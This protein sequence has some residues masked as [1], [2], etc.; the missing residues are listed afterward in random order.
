M[1]R[2]H[3]PR[4][5]EN[6]ALMFLRQYLRTPQ[7]VGAVIPSGPQLTELM[8]KALALPG[9]GTVI[10]LGPGTGVFTR[11]LIAAGVAPERLLLI[12]RN[13]DFARHLA[14]SFPG[15]EI[16]TGDARVL[17]SLMAARGEGLAKRIVSGL[18][19]RS[20]DDATRRSIAHAIG[21]TLAPWGRMAQF[22]YLGGPPIPHDHAADAGLIGTRCGIAL[23]NIPPAFVWQYVKA[24]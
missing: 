7:D 15:V 4:A 1:M 16:C 3:K 2:K 9:E 22:T 17:P 24:G 10:E 8:I 20:M 5:R 18:P 11:A 21:E 6:H 13:A 14:E 12:E 19:L 23:R